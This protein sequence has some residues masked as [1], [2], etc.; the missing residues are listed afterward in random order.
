MNELKISSETKFSI[1]IIG[2]I[3]FMGILV[4]TSLNVAMTTLSNYFDVTVGI[5]QWVTTIYLLLVTIMMGAAAFLMHTFSVRK[6]FFAA[7][8]TF[9]FGTFL[10][11]IA[12][13]FIILLLGRMAQAIATGISTPLMFQIIFDRIPRK[14]IGL[15][16]GIAT[17]IVTLAP[18]LGP[19]YGGILNTI[20]NWRYIFIFMFPVSFLIAMIGYFKIY[21][22]KASNHRKKFDWLG[23][24]WLSLTL[25]SFVY[26]FSLAGTYDW[27]SFEFIVMLLISMILVFILICHI[28]RTSN[29]IMDYRL[30]RNT[31]IRR[32]FINY[33]IISFINIG[34]AFVIPMVSEISL[35][36]S[37][38]T[39]GFLILP[40]AVLGSLIA[41]ITGKILDK[42]GAYLP[43]IIGNALILFSLIGF[44]FFAYEISIVFIIIFYL[45]LRVGIAFSFGNVMSSAS[46]LVE[47]QQK[48][49][50]NAILNVSQQYG[51]SLGT[52]LVAAIISSLQL[53]NSD[54]LETIRIGSMLD[55]ILLTILAA[56][57]LLL[58][59][60]NQRTEKK[61]K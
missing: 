49:D 60:S 7:I 33:F 34:I 59:F 18:A 4:E 50:I 48:G 57:A 61:Q 28:R 31:L 44:T 13:I 47:A 30:L 3:S 17:M 11:S 36:V 1:Y 23:M 51:G 9:L 38:M 37:S 35:H 10:C 39:A 52:V 12:N 43:L 41:P 22:S 19:S 40:G 8:F 26:A 45:I 14:K 15:Y 54:T 42:Y 5:V 25:I 58:V 32:H 16:N 29:N 2:A 56:Y 24:M 53:S 46:E 55:Y 27:L 21:K 6:L 20:L